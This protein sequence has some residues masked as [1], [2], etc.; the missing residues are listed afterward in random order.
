[1][2]HVSVAAF[3][4]GE[5]SGGQKAQGNSIARWSFL[6]YL[7]AFSMLAG[8]GGCAP[9]LNDAAKRETSPSGALVLNGTRVL[10]FKYLRTEGFVPGAPMFGDRE[11]LRPYH[12]ENLPGL[13]VRITRTGVP[14]PAAEQV[15][16]WVASAL[17]SL[18]LRS[19][20]RYEV[21]LVPAGQGHLARAVSMAPLTALKV[22]FV[23]PW[24]A[25]LAQTR[26]NLVDIL[27]HESFHLHWFMK[28]P[29]VPQDEVTAYWIGLCAQMRSG[30]R[31]TPSDLPGVELAGVGE[32]GV[33]SSRAAELVSRDAYQLMKKGEL[34]EQSPLGID[35]LVECDKAWTSGPTATRWW[36]DT[37]PAREAVRQD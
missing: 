22:K 24:Y 18:L 12:C 33:R 21:R 9:L 31:L 25:D 11:F 23:V 2:H 30:A 27:A 4:P 26:A 37:R 36:T 8:L 13:S 20:I 5:V 17:P 6:A 15:C 28:D 14:D 35:L 1:M 3:M 16:G 7:A 32:T 19:G 34:S 29:K 10:G